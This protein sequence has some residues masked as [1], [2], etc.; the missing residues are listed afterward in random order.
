MCGL[1]VVCNPCDETV[2][3]RSGYALGPCGEDIVVCE[4]TRVDVAALVKDHRRSVSRVDCP[5]YSDPAVDC[6]AARQKWVL[7]ICYDER[8]AHPVSSLKRP[9]SGC[10]CGGSC[11]GGCRGSS[12]SPS[13]GS[14]R[15]CGGSCSAP[16]SAPSS[17]APTQ[18]CEGF[19]FSLTRLPNPTRSL[20]RTE[21]TARHAE[22]ELS[23]RVLA[24][25]T[26]ITNRLTSVPPR[27]GE[28]VTYCCDLKADLREVI[29]TGDIHDCMLGQRLNEIVCPDPE[30]KD[31]N[32]KA[33]AAIA[34]M[35]QIAVDLFRSCVCSALLPPCGNDSPDDCVPLAVLTVRSSDLRVLDICN[36]SARKFAITMPA[37]SYWFGW[38]PIFDTVRTTLERLCCDAVRQPRFGITNNLT[39]T[40]RHVTKVQQS[41]S[42]NKAAPPPHGVKQNQESHNDIRAVE[43]SSAF[44]RIAAQYAET[45]SSLSGLEA[46]VLAALGARGTGGQHLASELELENPLAALT[47]AQIAAPAGAALLTPELA[48]RFRSS[49][50]Q[51]PT[52]VKAP[53][54]EDRLARLEASLAK[55]K[56]TVQT[57]ARTIERLS[58]QGPNR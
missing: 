16:P 38:M 30:D 49:L 43:E 54:D 2:T 5:P 29:E 31:A 55:L 50:S 22:G 32:D 15:G 24:C 11:G 47:I 25:L 8:P 10:S 45:W 41:E 52:P 27:G 19:R 34:A 58:G 1:E 35:L 56:R 7:G 40:E 26:N 46:T 21:P 12:K 13:G 36:W 39:V 17:C 6:E 42:P 33:R 57:Q 20:D 37:L 53:V 23:A 9:G 3:V 28:L 48:A 51:E 18:I 14:S 44:V 4:D